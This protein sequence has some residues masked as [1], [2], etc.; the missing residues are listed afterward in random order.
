MW[1]LTGTL[2]MIGGM[3]L[4]HVAADGAEGDGRERG[5]PPA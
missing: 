3:V 1:G 4:L 5:G 2:L